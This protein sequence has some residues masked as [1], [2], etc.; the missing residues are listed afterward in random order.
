MSQKVTSLIFL[1]LFSGSVSALTSICSSE[2]LPQTGMNTLKHE[3]SWSYHDNWFY[4]MYV[5]IGSEVEGPESL[6][7][8]DEFEMQVGG[9]VL[10]FLDGAPDGSYAIRGSV[11][12]GYPLPWGFDGYYQIECPEWAGELVNGHDTNDSS[13]TEATLESVTAGE[14]VQ[15]SPV[16]SCSQIEGTPCTVDSSSDSSNSITENQNFSGVDNFETPPVV[17]TGTLDAIDDS[18]LVLRTGVGR[19]L[20]IE[21]DSPPT[22][23]RKSLIDETAV[24]SGDT[25]GIYWASNE[26]SDTGALQV[27]VYRN[28]TPPVTIDIDRLAPSKNPGLEL[29]SIVDNVLLSESN[30]LQ[31]V[32]AQGKATLLVPQNAP[33]TLIEPASFDSLVPYNVKVRVTA[34]RAEDGSLRLHSIDLL[35]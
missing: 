6:S 35:N 11:R 30:E 34:T 7:V 21:I 27:R 1:L 9:S 33:V 13:N 19:Y 28:Q 20:N 4:N 18:S 10:Q 12:V 15:I 14:L 29:R 32:Y 23:T 17:A 8:V 16:D 26:E 22:I 3:A 2:F 24:R 25:V 5:E 31:L